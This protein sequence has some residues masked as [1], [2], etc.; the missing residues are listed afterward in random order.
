MNEA[1]HKVGNLVIYNEMGEFGNEHD[2]LLHIHAIRF[3]TCTGTTVNE[4]WYAGY[5][6]DIGESGSKGMPLIPIF[7]TTLTNATNK[8]LKAIDHLSIKFNPYR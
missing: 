5:L 6:L 8:K 2:R 4:H 7:G 1:L 3:G